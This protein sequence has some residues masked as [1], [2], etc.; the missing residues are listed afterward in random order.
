[1]ITTRAITRVAVGL[2]L[3]ACAI[4]ALAAD[5]AGADAAASCS[6]PVHSQMELR[7]LDRATQ[8]PDALR[9]KQQPDVLANLAD[10]SDVCLWHL[11]SFRG[12]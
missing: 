12:D 9:L 1:M 2:T 11:A 3:A 7:V 10:D 8:G 5:A 6:A 4:A